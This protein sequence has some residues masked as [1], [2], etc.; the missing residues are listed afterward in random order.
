MINIH[1]NVAVKGKNCSR[2]H[3][4]FSHPNYLFDVIFFEILFF[5]LGADL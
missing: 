2:F 3:V 5:S 4:S 1:N